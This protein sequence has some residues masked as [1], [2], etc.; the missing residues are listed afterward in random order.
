M[1]VE[2]DKKRRRTEEESK[3][4]CNTFFI[5][6]EYAIFMSKTRNAS[7]QAETHCNFAWIS[8]ILANEGLDQTHT[9]LEETTK[10]STRK[11]DCKLIRIVYQIVVRIEIDCCC[12]ALKTVCFDAQQSLQIQVF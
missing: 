4:K 6:D 12:N 2:R 11:V 5:F 8:A 1:Y 7:L 10:G 3:K 9:S